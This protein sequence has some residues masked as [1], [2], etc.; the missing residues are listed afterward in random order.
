[1]SD[2]DALLAKSAIETVLK[3]YCRSMDRI[4]AE[5]G[6]GVWHEGG[7]ADYGPIFQG[8][9]RGFI[10]WVCDFHRTLDATSHQIA[11][12]LIDVQGDR[13]TSET[14]ITVSLLGTKDGQRTLTVGRGRYLDEWSRRDGRW[15]IDR[16]RYVTDFAISEEGVTAA[17]GWGKRDSGD[18]SY[19]LLGAIGAA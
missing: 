2:L 5:L 15:A 13:A 4:D 16:R 11:N 1:M 18:L 8:T 12:I 6:Y 19:A 17:D 10:D 3:R 7:V 9:G 14:Y